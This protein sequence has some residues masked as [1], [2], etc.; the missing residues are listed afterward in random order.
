MNLVSIDLTDLDFSNVIAT[1]N[2]IFNCS[3]LEDI[4]FSSDINT[5]RLVSMVSMFDFCSSLVSVDLSKFNTENV[6]NMANMFK[7]CTL[8]ESLD[9]RSFSTK[10]CTDLSCMFC[11]CNSLIDIKFGD[12]FS[13]S[14]VEVFNKMFISCSSLKS[15]T[16]PLKPRKGVDFSYM[17]YNCKSLESL[18]LG[19]FTMDEDINNYSDM[20]G[21]CQNLKKLNSS[22]ELSDDKLKYVG[23][24]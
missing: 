4:K 9:L 2:M 20:F 17:F 24:A 19:E 21:W 12:K 8:I 13:C 15:L 22:L 11:D 1:N 23:L 10:S 5:S 16:L 6:T 14:N 7:D 18:D 3:M